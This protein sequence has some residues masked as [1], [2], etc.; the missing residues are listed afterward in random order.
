MRPT[1]FHGADVKG[2]LRSAI[3]RAS[4]LELAMDLLGFGF[5]QRSQLAFGQDEPLLG[6]L[7]FQRL[8]ALL[9]G[10]KIIP[11]PDP[12]HASRRDR[13]A[14]LA[15]LVVE[16]DLTEGGLLQGKLD[17]DRFH[18]GRGAAD[19]STNPLPKGSVHI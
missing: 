19:T 13:L 18:L 15:H 3:A 6:H 17:N 1:P 8:E 9:H 12:A 14:V 16:A 7:G 11:L 2:V 5:L 4:A 10:F